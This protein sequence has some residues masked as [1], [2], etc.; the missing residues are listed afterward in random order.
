VIIVL[1][2]VS[3]SGKST[4]GQRLAHELSWTFVDADDFHSAHNIEKLR[5]GIPLND[6]DRRPWLAALRHRLERAHAHAE[7]VVLACSALK[8][9]YQDYLAA[10]DPD[11]LRYVF[12]VGSEALIQQRLAERKGHFMDPNLLHSQLE[13]LEPPEDAL[14]VDITP[15]PE[16][17]TATI[18]RQLGL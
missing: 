14:Q 6:D 7:N 18:R 1:M 16:V 11:G 9:S 8:H 15:P 13:T 5:Q 4:I 17:I 10:A 2:G 12:L 3:G